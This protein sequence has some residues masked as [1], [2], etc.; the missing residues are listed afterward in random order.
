M[1]ST[2]TCPAR[3]PERGQPPQRAGAEQ[4]AL[5]GGEPALGEQP[6][7]H[8]AGRRPGGEEPAPGAHQVD[9]LAGHQRVGEGHAVHVF[10]VAAHRQPARQAGDL[11]PEPASS[12]WM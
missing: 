11:T 5:V 10:E 1:V 8:P 12:C 7:A 2:P 4:V 3:K 9:F 6:A